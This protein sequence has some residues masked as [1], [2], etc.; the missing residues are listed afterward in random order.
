L[1]DLLE[2]AR[3][4]RALR[5]QLNS[6]L[7]EPTPELVAQHEPLAAL[8]ARIAEQEAAALAELER[9]PETRHLAA[10]RRALE[11]LGGPLD[12][13]YENSFARFAR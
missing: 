1:T 4:I 12:N 5:R 9:N 8:E 3:Q 13:K 6:R 10:I 7:L 2:S 11:A